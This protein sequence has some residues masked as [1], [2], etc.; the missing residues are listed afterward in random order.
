MIKITQIPVFFTIYT[1]YDLSPPRKPKIKEE[2]LSA[3]DNDLSPP[4]TTL[5]QEEGQVNYRD[6]SGRKISKEEWLK[7]N[8]RQPKKKHRIETEKELSWGG[9]IVQRNSMQERAAEEKRIMEAPLT[10]HEIDADYDEELRQKPRWDDP[11]SKFSK[12][13]DSAKP[14]PKCAFTC[15]PNRFGIPPGYRWD[16][17]V[18]GNGYEEKLLDAQNTR[19]HREQEAY[20][21]NTADM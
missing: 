4:R 13:E 10:R 2:E 15:P 9:G 14:K 12:E 20:K 21:W 18:R 8:A 3:S 11:M 19:K 1:L 5:Q 17:K 6:K 7:L 16:G